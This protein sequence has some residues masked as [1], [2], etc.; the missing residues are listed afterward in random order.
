MP[1]KLSSLSIL[2]TINQL[3][4][5]KKADW[6]SISGLRPKDT[7]MILIPFKSPQ[8]PLALNRLL[9]SSQLFFSIQ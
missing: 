7:E 5:W 3:L 6:N 2:L 8:Y 1:S 9:S 4:N